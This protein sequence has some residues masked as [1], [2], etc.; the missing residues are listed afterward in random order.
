[1]DCNQDRLNDDM[2]LL[3]VLKIVPYKYSIKLYET[4]RD[5]YNYILL[6]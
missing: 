6:E 2:I 3:I 4:N 1:M 5:Q